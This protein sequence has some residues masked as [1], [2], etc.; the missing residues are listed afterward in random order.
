MT[1][2]LKRFSETKQGNRKH[3]HTPHTQTTRIGIYILI[4]FKKDVLTE[5]F[6]HL[7]GWEIGAGRLAEEFLLQALLAVGPGAP[8]PGG[9]AT[10]IAN[11]GSECAQTV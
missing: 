1:T 4:F 10:V 11:I 7:D 2:I 8:S 6:G 3:K 5:G 9:L